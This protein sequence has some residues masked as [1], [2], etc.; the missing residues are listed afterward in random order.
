MSFN[1]FGDFGVCSIKKKLES[2]HFTRNDNMIN[3]M[4]NAFTL[5]SFI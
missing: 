1:R 4:P 2:L 5:S 3:V